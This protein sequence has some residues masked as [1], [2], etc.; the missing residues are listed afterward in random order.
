MLRSG[1]TQASL[2]LQAC[3]AGNMLR[4]CTFDPKA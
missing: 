3:S 2:R 4:L 1:T